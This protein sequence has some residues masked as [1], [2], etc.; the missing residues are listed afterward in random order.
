[1]RY[2]GRDR[3]CSHA[4]SLAKRKLIALRR[5]SHSGRTVIRPIPLGRSAALALF[6]ADV[7]DAAEDRE[8]LAAGA[9]VLGAELAGEALFCGYTKLVIS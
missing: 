3:S 7:L 4:Q 2:A 8:D 6:V 1:M 9:A 5:S